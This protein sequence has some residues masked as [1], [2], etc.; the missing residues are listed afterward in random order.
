ME[1]LKDEN[2]GVELAGSLSSQE[3]I[4]GR[5][6]RIAAQTLRPDA[7]LV[8]EGAPA[9][10]PYEPEWAAQTALRKGPNLRCADGSMITNP[11]FHK[12]AMETARK[13]SIKAQAGVRQGS[14][15]NGGLIHV[16]GQGVPCIVL[17]VPVRYAH[18]PC[19]ISTMEDFESTVNLAVEVLRTLDAQVI[20][21]F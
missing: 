5:G 4:G 10:D 16:T 1:T 20:G 13:N 21:K 14:G 11:R 18:S 7:A 6:A 8:F 19:G 17:G 3:E 9:D 15:T 12:L 2:L